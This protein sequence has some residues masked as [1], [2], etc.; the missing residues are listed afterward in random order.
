LENLEKAKL[1]LGSVAKGS[2]S[3]G[4]RKATY[5]DSSDFKLRRQGF[6]LYIC[7]RDG[8]RTQVLTTVLD[9]WEDAVASDRPDL[10][11][12]ETGPHLRDVVAPDEL[13]PL[14]KTIVQRTTIAI[15]PGPSIRI[16]AAIDE[17]EI[18][19]AT[20]NT[21]EALC[22][23]EL[24][25]KN[26]D[27][28]AL[29][30]VAMR[31]L[32]AASLRIEARSKAARG[33]M[34]VATEGG[35]VAAVHAPPIALHGSMTVESVLQN[36]GRGCIGH[37]LCNDPGAL[38]GDAEAVH[39]MRVASRRLGTALSALKPMIPADQY[40]WALAE[41]KWLA[42]ELG[43]ARNWDVF[44]ASLLWPV[45]QALPLDA[46]LKR[47]AQAVEQQRRAAYERVKEAIGSQ[48]YTAALLQLARWLEAR[49]W[50]DQPAS[51]KAALLF[52]RI[53][54]VA[55]QL[56]EHRWRRAR[57]RSWQFGR[58]SPDERHKLR[59]SLKKLR[60]TIDL[61]EDLFDGD[62]VQAL[63]RRLKPLQ[64]SLGHAN[65]VRTAHLL[66]EEVSRHLNEGGNEI[67]CAGGIMLGWHDRGLA[68]R[69]P[70]LRK[71]VRRLRR[72]KPF[73]PRTAPVSATTPAKPLTPKAV[74]QAAQVPED[75]LQEVGDSRA[76]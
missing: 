70:K 14:F 44:T 23:I 69:E 60:Y 37:L 73:W 75:Q 59:I 47:L 68:D 19:G 9:E 76:G 6:N 64:E 48:R 13:R 63:V 8:R 52:A 3:S 53:G 74:Q 36:I 16:E 61:L 62:D 10:A 46:G 35:S 41:L 21:W 4:A 17:G 66:I 33:Y 27:S 5:Y 18:H 49:G 54:D 24:E 1:L 67:S 2:P 38:A 7:E 32:D 26:G 71:D 65:D 29:Y 57:K 12:P 20:G 11:A 31:L 50:R 43:P 22:E 72:A 55:P 39:Q 15:E 56:I 28:A 34:L 42:G 40:R 58:L 45:E 51:E 25:L 30:D